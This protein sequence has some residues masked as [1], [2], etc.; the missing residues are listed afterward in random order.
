MMV[1][2]WP[3][4]RSALFLGLRGYIIKYRLSAIHM[5]AVCPR[6]FMLL[7]VAFN[8]FF[9]ELAVED[10]DAKLIHYLIL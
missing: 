9:Y 7:N 8:A 1:L 4:T 2:T 5:I 6:I 3:V 10:R